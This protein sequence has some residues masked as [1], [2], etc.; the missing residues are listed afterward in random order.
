M[1]TL[2]RQEKRHNERTSKDANETLNILKDR[3]CDYFFTC[4]DPDNE[5]TQT[6]IKTVSAQW[7]GFCRRKNLLAKF[8]PIMDDFCNEVVKEYRENKE[9]ENPPIQDKVSYNPPAL[10]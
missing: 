4:A 5:E 7:R 8:F 10:Q 2:T 1:S 6:R 9:K 3:F